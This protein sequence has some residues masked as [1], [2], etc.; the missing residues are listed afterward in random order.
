VWDFLLIGIEGS[1][2]GSLYGE[3]EF[4]GNGVEVLMEE[5]FSD[6]DFIGSALELRNWKE[7]DHAAGG[8]MS[9]WFTRMGNHL[10][11]IIW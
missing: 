9:C 3:E 6:G 11:L 10:F 1:L 8:L 5:L 4:G 2:V 7:C